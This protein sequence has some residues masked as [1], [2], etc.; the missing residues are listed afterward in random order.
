VTTGLERFEF[1]GS[2]RFVAALTTAILGTAVTT[3]PLQRM[4]GWPGLIGVL[5][6]LLA[7]AAASTLLRWRVL[8]WRG[9]LPISLI[10]F[11]VW[12]GLSVLWSAYQWATLAGVIYLVAFGAL[13]IF[14]ALTRDVIQLVRAF[15]DVLRA[16]LAAGLVLEV[17]AGVLVDSPIRLLNI[18]GAIAEGGPIQGLAGDST[19]LAILALLGLVTF[20]VE[21]MTRSVRKSV[22]VASLA[23][24]VLVI[25]LSQ[26]GVVIAAGFVVIL[27]ALALAG[28]RR[29]GAPY[30]PPIVWSLAA[31]GVVLVVVV[32][33]LRDRV[34]GLLESS[35]QAATRIGLWR[36]VT[37]LAELHSLEGWGWIGRWRIELDPFSYFW[38][39]ENTT[40][41]SAFNAY[42]DVALQVGLVG[43]V[44][45][46]GLLGLVVIRSL[47]LAV[48]QK[49]VVY[50]WPALVV[51]VLLCTSLTE[52]VLLT[53]LG[54]MMLVVCVVKS[55]NKLSWRSAF[56]R[57]RPRTTPPELPTSR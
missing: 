48:R 34:L 26:S 30:R 20:G 42:L 5:A 56:E 9:I 35:D 19:H 22:S 52:S 15:G 7:L 41:A 54:W 57:V 25:L 37:N 32:I 18:R 51:V 40:Y 47:H 43:L 45:F 53:E 4:I 33:V 29:A 50:L 17:I 44:L 46:C 11:V 23:V 24:G 31:V 38:Q 8:D 21:L 1:L 10:A 39:V 16:V 27:V 12:C 36:G 13:G 28:I 14:L 55:A 49:S 6:G 2:P 3:F